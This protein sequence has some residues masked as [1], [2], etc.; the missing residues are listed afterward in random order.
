MIQQ[1]VRWCYVRRDDIYT[2]KLLWF[3]GRLVYLKFGVLDLGERTSKA[4][5][6][7]VVVWKILKPFV[8]LVELNRPR[9][10][11]AMSDQNISPIFHL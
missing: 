7:Q 4:I 3:K 5:S 10:L 1:G 11:N 9:Q 8:A 2:Q 6:E